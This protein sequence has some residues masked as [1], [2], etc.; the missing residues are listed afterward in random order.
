MSLR[1][2]QGD[3]RTSPIIKAK[4][5]LSNGDEAEA[6]AVLKEIASQGNVMACYDAGFMMIQGIGC[7]KDLRGGLE[8]MRKGTKLEEDS[9]ETSWGLY[10]SATALIEPLTMF[11]G[12]EF[13]LVNL[14]LNDDLDDRISS[15]FHHF[16]LNSHI[17]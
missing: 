13:S 14:I 17:N 11:V 16:F 9:E 8:L 3:T 10:G 7:F 2:Q 12:G 15:H 1:P 4:S 6:L 5:L